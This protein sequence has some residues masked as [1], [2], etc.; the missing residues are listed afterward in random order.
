MSEIKVGLIGLGTVGTGLARLFFEHGN[1]LDDR[2][3][4]PIRLTRIA[5]LDITT[6]RGIRIPEGILT[7][8]VDSILD[9]PEIDIVVELI[10]GLNPTREFINRALAAGKQVVTANKALLAHHGNDIF[11]RAEAAGC[12]VYYEAAVAVGIPIIRSLREGLSAN[13]VQTLTAI[14]NG[15]SNYILT[16]MT[17]L[18]EPYAQALTKAQTEGIAEADPGLDVGGHDP[19]HKLALLVSLAFGGKIQYSELPVE[20]IEAVEDADIA[21]AREF[22]FVIKPL[23][24][25]R[26]N[27]EEVDARVHP[28]MIPEDHVMAAVSDAFNAIHITAD[29]V[30]EVLFYGRGA[31]QQPT[32]SAVAGDVLEAARNLMACDKVR[33]P[34]LGAPGRLERALKLKP[35]D[36]LV[37]RYYVRLNVLD[38]PGVLSQ[39]TGILADHDISIRE[40]VQKAEGEASVPV[41]MLTHPA[42]ESEMDAALAKMTEM[43]T[44]SRPPVKYRIVED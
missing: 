4:S 38:K 28:A 9:D 43:D 33:L 14:L 10:G 27:G 36:E 12:G 37:C 40:V 24:I 3:G 22:G 1:R 7:T 5:D 13:R 2:L 26:R 42:R 39:V 19:A 11:G 34:A 20:G 41:V 23:A 15:T 29:P 30:D 6:D 44:L 16:R 8:E 35:L 32:A 18:D 31:G 21:F 25:A 17:R